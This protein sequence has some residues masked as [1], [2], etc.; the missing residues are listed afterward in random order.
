MSAHLWQLDLLH[1]AHGEVLEH[2][3]VR[4]REEGEHHLDEVA[5]VIREALPVLEVVR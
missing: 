2:D 5:L 3:S 1:E 4:L